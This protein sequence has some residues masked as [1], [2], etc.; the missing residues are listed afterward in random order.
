MQRPREVTL[1]VR[2]CWISVV[3]ALPSVI[4]GFA[5]TWTEDAEPV[6]MVGAGIFS[7]AVLAFAVWVILSLARARHW[8]R[9]VYSVL[10]VFGVVA[11]AMTFSETLARPW[12]SWLAGLVSTLMDVVIVVLLFR[13]AS[14]AWYRA[15]GRRPADAPA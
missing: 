4:D 15:R 7:A 2:L 10:T 5:E 9:I 11:L 12:Y 13:P 8:A 14:N 6:A 3:V 1:A